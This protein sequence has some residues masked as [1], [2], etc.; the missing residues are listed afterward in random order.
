MGVCFLEVL[1]QLEIRALSYNTVGTK[2]LLN[3]LVLDKQSNRTETAV[4]IL[5]ALTARLSP[6]DLQPVQG[7]VMWVSIQIRVGCAW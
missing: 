6:F 3:E 4:D 7:L 5:Q 1:I 2:L